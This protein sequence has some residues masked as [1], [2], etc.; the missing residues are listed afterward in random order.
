MPPAD[1]QGRSRVRFDAHAV[2]PSVTKPAGA[3]PAACGA[4]AASGAA[5]LPHPQPWKA[6]SRVADRGQAV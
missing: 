2:V 5:P 4:V 3:N 1:R 6:V